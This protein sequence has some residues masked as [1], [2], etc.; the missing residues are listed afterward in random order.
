MEG[1]K[2]KNVGL[3][4]CIMGLAFI[5]F[6]SGG[7]I[8]LTSVVSNENVRNRVYELA[9]I[10]PGMVEELKDGGSISLN[11]VQMNVLASGYQSAFRMQDV[12][13]VSEI[14]WT[15][16][17]M[18]S[19]GIFLLDLEDDKLKKQIASL[20]F[21]E[22]ILALFPIGATFTSSLSF[23]LFAAQTLLI[24]AIVATMVLVF[25]TIIITRHAGK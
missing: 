2:L 16:S 25:D 20:I 6:I 17:I 3:V 21:L 14:L 24:I 10:T 15:L 1:N 9:G 11:A 8:N 23:S 18:I 5:I 13:I 19:L 7:L 4:A 22:N 12:L